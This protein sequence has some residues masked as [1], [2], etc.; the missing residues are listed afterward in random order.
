M[1]KNDFAN[2]FSENLNYYMALNHKTQTDL[3]NDLKVSKATASSW[4]N[5]IRVP[6]FDK[7]DKLCRYL[8]I[9]KADLIEPRD[10]DPFKHSDSDLELLTDFY[11][12]AP[13]NVQR[14][15]SVLVK[16]YFKK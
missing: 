5:G 16:Y 3:V 9:D 12:T 8:H 11:K 10:P 15:I 13:T 1:D 14:A 7:M 2:V 4:C 6:R